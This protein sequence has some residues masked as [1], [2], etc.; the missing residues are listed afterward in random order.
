MSEVDNTSVEEYTFDNPSKG[1]EFKDHCEDISRWN[2]EKVHIRGFNDAV[3]GDGTA[4]KKA[5]GFSQRYIFSKW[6]RFISQD[7]FSLT[8]Q[9][10]SKKFEFLAQTPLIITFYCIFKL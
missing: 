1:P 3:E 8:R 4:G 10:T 2:V 7:F 6:N 9:W 5:Y